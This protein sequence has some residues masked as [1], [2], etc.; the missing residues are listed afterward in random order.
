M[1]MKY[2]VALF[3]V[4]FVFFTTLFG[5]EANTEQPLDLDRAYAI[6]NE[7]V[8]GRI[9]IIYTLTL[10]EQI[11]VL[12]IMEE[13]RIYPRE[14]PVAIDGIM[15]NQWQPFE[16][17]NPNLPSCSGYW[18]YYACAETIE[19]RENTSG[20]LYEI[21]P[22]CYMD[23]PGSDCGSDDDDY[24]LSF[25]FG[26]H[27]ESYSQLRYQLKWYST[28]WFARWYLLT[29]H[30]GRM[31]GRLYQ[32]N[33]QSGRDNYNVYVCVPGFLGPYLHTFKMRKY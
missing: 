4:W 13:E 31:S 15:F 3:V 23:A 32:Q 30:Q 29:F 33:P 28:N 16:T 26:N 11:Q 9:E 25:Y 8:E 21:G 2:A 7:L 18:G 24:M 5:Q 19:Y 17:D 12:R 20:L 27:A 6:I 1:D 14:T 10:M 22:N